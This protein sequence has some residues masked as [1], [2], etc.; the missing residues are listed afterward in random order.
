[1]K[2]NLDVINASVP[3]R[4]YNGTP[5]AT[6]VNAILDPSDI[7]GTETLTLVLGNHTTGTF[8][9]TAATGANSGANVSNGK[10]VTTAMT[11]TGPTAANYTLIQPTL[12]G[13]VTP[14]T[15]TFTAVSI[16][17]KVFDGVTPAVATVAGVGASTTW[18]GLISGDA[19]KFSVN[20][21]GAAAT[22]NN[23]WP[24]T[25]KP[26]TVTGGI[27]MSTNVGHTAT[28]NAGNYEIVYPI[29][30]TGT[31]LPPAYAMFTP[32]YAV[33]RPFVPV[34]NVPINTPLS[35]EFSVNV[36]DINGDVLPTTDLG[37]FI[38][39]QNLMDLHGLM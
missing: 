14:R 10:N 21:S 17:P 15:L 36:V 38:D 33:N 4:P 25:G 23:Q 24:G 20:V 13:D 8:A 16:T 34:Q 30:T 18:T 9:G 28:Y 26:V 32:T 22:F 27:A 7:V 2:K 3:S 37:D 11:L 1:L 39:F 5:V 31:I 19:A 12:I 35:V 6:I 29:N